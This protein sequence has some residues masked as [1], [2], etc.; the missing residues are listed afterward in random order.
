[1]VWLHLPKHIQAEIFTDEI[2]ATI[3]DN[4]WRHALHCLVLFGCQQAGGNST[5]SEMIPDMAHC[6]GV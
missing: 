2:Q 4:S 1:L 5:G 6:R 3:S